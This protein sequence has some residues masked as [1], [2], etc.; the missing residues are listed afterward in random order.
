VKMVLV[1]DTDDDAGMKS[2]LKIMRQ[3]AADHGLDNIMANPHDPKFAKIEFIKMLRDYQAFAKIEEDN[4][5]DRTALYSLKKFVD[6]VWT[7]KKS[8]G[9]YKPRWRV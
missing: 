7:Q 9:Y 3:L 6:E 1:F 2:S 5:E 8:G 4:G